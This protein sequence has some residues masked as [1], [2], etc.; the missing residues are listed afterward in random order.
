MKNY[1]ITSR[2]SIKGETL[3]DAI[4]NGFG[5]I[6]DELHLGNG[7]G[8]Q[9]HQVWCEYDPAR[10]AAVLHIIAS[11]S[12][13]AV[14]YDPTKDAPKEY[15]LTIKAPP[16][17]CPQRID[18]DLTEKPDF[19]P[20]NDEC[21]TSP[22]A[23]AGA[24][25][26]I[27]DEIGQNRCKIK[28]DSLVTTQIMRRQPN[29]RIAYPLRYIELCRQELARRRP[30]T[31]NETTRLMERVSELAAKLLEIP[32]GQF[33]SEVIF[34]SKTATYFRTN[35]KITALAKIRAQ[36]GMTQVQLAEAVNMSTRQIQNYERC[37]GSTLWSAAQSVH[38]Q[39]AA[40]LG[41]KRSDI[42]DEA[43]SAVLIDKD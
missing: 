31:S 26:G 34:H 11:G 15:T 4:E 32:D 39:L 5:R 14:N 18:F 41:V 28:E 27:I 33:S 22:S 37:P 16:E 17:D 29:L 40:A 25:L 13:I 24:L 3:K 21:L 35:G 23:I 9:L 7:A 38:E 20:F 12:D 30:R 43:G 6:A 2:L 8:Y 1:Q 10:Q 42:V 19:D 36:K